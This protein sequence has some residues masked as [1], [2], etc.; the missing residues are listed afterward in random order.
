[1][2][3]IDVQFRFSLIEVSS[4]DADH[5]PVLL[6]HLDVVAQFL[7]DVLDLVRLEAVE[8]DDPDDEVGLLSIFHQL[9][10]RT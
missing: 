9:V 5:A 3:H 6:L 10:N 2:R 4:L 1:M 7:Q 8:A